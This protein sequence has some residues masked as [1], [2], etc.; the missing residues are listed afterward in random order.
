MASP[1]QD[2]IKQIQDLATDVGNLFQLRGFKAGGTA[3]Q[4]PVK[5]DGT[6]F[7]WSWGD[8]AESVTVDSTVI[9]GS[10][11]AVSGN[12][13]FDALAAKA[14]A[15]GIAPSAITGTAVV[16]SELTAKKGIRVFADFAAMDAAAPEYIGQPAVR[17]SDGKTFT[18]VGLAVGIAS[19]D[20]FYKS[21]Y[22]ESAQFSG[23][24]A[25]LTGISLTTG[26]TGE[27]PP[28]N[29]AGGATGKSVLAAGTNATAWTALGGTGTAASPTFTGM[30]MPTNTGVVD[31]GLQR[32]LSTNFGVFEIDSGNTNDFRDFRGRRMLFGLSGV[33]IGDGS[34]G[35]AQINN[36]TSGTFRDLK[37][38]NMESTGTLTGTEQGS[39]PAAPSANGYVIYAED[40]GSG[41]TRLMV[42][43][44]TGAA[45]QIAIE[46]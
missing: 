3:G 22:V 32:R 28:A 45:Q 13:V 41:K 1:L 8:A 27:L 11:N 6:D 29:L 42:R 4:V 19:W 25:G 35:V 5:T 20:A 44:A 12:A 36:G 33:A 39:T 26:V 16:Q 15:T 23:G 38:R 24:G 43:F 18:G 34:S 30:T 46:P 37:L 7:N 17:L 10:T 2:L 14:P 40:N 9:D 31:F 21:D